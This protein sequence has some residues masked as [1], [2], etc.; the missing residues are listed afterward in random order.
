MKSWAC[1]LDFAMPHPARFVAR[2]CVFP[3]LK[4]PDRKAQGNALG[5]DGEL[6]ESAL[7]GRDR[8]CC[9]PSGHCRRRRIGTVPSLVPRALP[10]AFLF[11]PFRAGNTEARAQENRQEP[12]TR[13]SPT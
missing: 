1:C 7:K 3:A 10:G 12:Q 2:R 6:Y 9:A 11:G 4:G 5:I 8:I 13:S